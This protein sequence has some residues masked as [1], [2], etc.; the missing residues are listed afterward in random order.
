MSKDDFD[1]R[2]LKTASIKEEEQ[3]ASDQEK[4]DQAYRGSARLARY[5][6][7][8][9]VV[10]HLSHLRIL[11]GGSFHDAVPAGCDIPGTGIRALVFG[12]AQGLL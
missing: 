7:K 8:S 6:L 2:F 10:R 4:D 1:E 3:T 9:A 5:R 12:R 11:E